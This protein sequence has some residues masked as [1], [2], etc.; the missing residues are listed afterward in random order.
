MRFMAKPVREIA[1]ISGRGASHVRR[2]SLSTTTSDQTKPSP[3][4][5]RLDSFKLRLSR[6]AHN[7]SPAGFNVTPHE[8]DTLR[9]RWPLTR[10]LESSPGRHTANTLDNESR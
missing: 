2:S 7:A 10:A 4:H 5:A 9:T 8:K 1:F 6:T 3:S